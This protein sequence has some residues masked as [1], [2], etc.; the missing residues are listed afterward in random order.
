MVSI[1]EPE[2]ILDYN[3]VNFLPIRSFS[4]MVLWI[5]TFVDHNIGASSR[6]NVSSQ[7]V[8]NS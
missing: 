4:K 8:I 2:S 6:T 7:A 1:L 5:K 3:H